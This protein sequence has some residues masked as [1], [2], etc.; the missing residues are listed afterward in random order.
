VGGGGHQGIKVSASIDVFG[1]V[2]IIEKSSV[3]CA[4]TLARCRCRRKELGPSIGALLHA[5]E[6][7]AADRFTVAEDRGKDIG[8]VG[9]VTRSFPL[10][11]GDQKKRIKS[12]DR[13]EDHG[14][15]K[16]GS[17]DRGTTEQNKERMEEATPGAVG[18][19]VEKRIGRP[20]R[21]RMIN[22]STQTLPDARRPLGQ[23]RATMRRDLLP[24][25]IKDSENTKAQISLFR[26]EVATGK[27]GQAQDPR[28]L[29]RQAQ[30][31]KEPNMAESSKVLSRR[32]GEDS[33]KRMRGK[34]G[35]MSPTLSKRNG[36][37]RED[38]QFRRAGRSAQSR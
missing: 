8:A 38:I 7:K 19:K 30:G 29:R 23:G 18:G 35:V 31:V 4:Q 11:T 26:A 25:N 5:R 21:K 36:F 14:A 1:K 22:A 9:S 10:G 33:K 28:T 6:I 24:A 20:S 37:Q 27:K 32:R 12:F 3:D 17:P 16:S 2:R 15:G 34:P 13:Q